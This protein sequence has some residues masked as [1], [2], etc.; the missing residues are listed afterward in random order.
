MRKP[1]VAAR[2]AADVPRRRAPVPAADE[3]DGSYT[4]P[5][6]P[7]SRSPA[8]L[9]NVQRQRWPRR[10]QR[11]EGPMARRRSSTSRSS[12][13][14]FGAPVVVNTARPT[15]TAVAGDVPGVAGDNV[16]EGS[17]ARQFLPQ[18]ATPG[19]WTSGRLPTTPPTTRTTASPGT[20]W[21]SKRSIQE[22]RLGHLRLLHEIG[23]PPLLVTDTLSRRYGTTNDRFGD[24]QRIRP[25]AERDLRVWS[26]GT[27]KTTESSSPKSRTTVAANNRAGPHGELTGSNATT[28][29]ARGSPSRKSPGAA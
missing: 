18:T 22:R 14:F 5:S 15:G 1:R 3:R 24:V 17:S 11:R 2:L 10:C 16:Y 13:R 28:T 23:M 12:D 9:R 4:S 26:A 19:Q 27:A 8:A 29:S 21:S 20:R 6:A 25:H 7:A